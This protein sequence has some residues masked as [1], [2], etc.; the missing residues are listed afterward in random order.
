MDQS[1]ETADDEELLA[2]NWY[3][4]RDPPLTSQEALEDLRE[5]YKNPL[6]PISF[7]SISKVYQYYNGV[8]SK[9]KIKE[10][11]S[12]T[13]VGTL[14]ASQP[15]NR[16]KKWTPTIS[17]HYL[18]LI[19]IDL[20]DV[21]KLS[22]ENNDIKFLL[23]AIDVFTRKLFVQP[24]L[25]KKADSVLEAFKTI[26]AFM[27][28]L[29][30]NVTSDN[31]GEFVNAKMKTMLKK[32]KVK[33][34]ISVSDNKCSTVEAAQKS[35]QRRLYKFMVDRESLRYV[36]V[37]PEIV[38]SYNRCRHRIL[39]MS[40]NEARLQKNFV[41]LQ[42]TNMN[43]L[44]RLHRVKPVVSYKVGDHVRVAIDRAKTPFMRSYDVQWSEARYQI[45]KI[46]TKASIHAKYFLKHIDSDEKITGGWFYD[47][48]L[49]K[50]TVK[51]YRGRVISRRMKKGRKQ[52]KFTF[53]GYPPK[54]DQWL[55]EDDV[56]SDM[57]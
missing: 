40:P 9:R 53:A 54:F 45:W 49:L 33:F 36:D 29:P 2:D 19:Q 42:M 34:H 11:L 20:V 52:V 1:E 41:K 37:L 44:S 14:M 32:L 16:S 21:S 26:L 18:D 8:L 43:R 13:E 56:S 7:L 57:G 12:S 6:N 25:D 30:D 15:P 50:T 38:E 46:S 55:D 17:F 39:G 51:T 28:R 24:T 35:L 31:G 4:V 10:Y 3:P 27:E 48:Q 47:R 22:E 5:Q 23:C